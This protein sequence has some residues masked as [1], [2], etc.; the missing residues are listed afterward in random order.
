MVEEGS[1]TVRSRTTGQE[2]VYNAGESID[3]TPAGVTTSTAELQ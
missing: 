3:I 2:M 1:V